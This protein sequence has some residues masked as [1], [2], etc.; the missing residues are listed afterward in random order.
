MGFPETGIGIYPGLGG[1]Q[2]TARRVGIPLARWLVLSGENVNA[3]TGHQLGLI[4]AV[5]STTELDA[6]VAEYALSEKAAKEGSVPTTVPSGY[7]EMAEL[8][9]APLADLKAGTVQVDGDFANIA[10]KIMKKIGFKA[11]LALEAANDL[12]QGAAEGSLADGLKRETAGL[13]AIFRSA[14]A[15]EGMSALGKRRPH[16]SGK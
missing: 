10:A 16:F 4:D 12:L 9:T 14:D 13:D 7:E 2:R 11:P 3:K 6:K 5:V 15:L 1:T 8:F